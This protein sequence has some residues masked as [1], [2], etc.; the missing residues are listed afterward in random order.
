MDKSL[1]G[2]AEAV[3]LSSIRSD[4]SRSVV[5]MSRTGRGLGKG[6]REFGP[7]DICCNERI[8][9]LVRPCGIG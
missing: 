2:A 8:R 9:K 6:L 3:K 7:D 4:G 5:S 1:P